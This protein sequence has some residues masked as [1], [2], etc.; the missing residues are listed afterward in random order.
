MYYK[1]FIEFLKTHNIYDEEIVKYFNNNSTRFDYLEEEYRPFIGV[2]YMTEGDI[3][4]KVKPMVPFINSDKT[5]LIN[6]HEY[7]HLYL[8]YNKINKPVNIMTRDREVLP[9]FYEKVFVK[10]N[11]SLELLKYHEHLNESIYNEGQDEYL[12]AL[13]L[14]N[15]LIDSYENDDIKKLNHKVKRLVLKD[16]FSRLVNGK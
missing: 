8:I 13:K 12:L 9:I 14:S 1:K 3:L 6:I 10:E 7:I 11:P 2:Y 5:V 4:T 16:N 15:E